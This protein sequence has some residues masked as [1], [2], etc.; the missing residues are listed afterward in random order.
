MSNKNTISEVY[1][2]QPDLVS[3]HKKYLDIIGWAEFH[4]NTPITPALAWDINTGIVAVDGTEENLPAG[5]YM[6]DTLLLGH[7]TWQI[8]M[9]LAALIEAIFVV[10]GEPDTAIRQ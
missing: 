3:K 10:M 7:S 9:K 1:T 8:M 5:I 6:D 2:N 4:P